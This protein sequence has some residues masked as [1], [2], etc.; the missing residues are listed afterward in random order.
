MT[1]LH[2]TAPRRLLGTLVALFGIGLGGCASTNVGN[3]WQCPLLQGSVCARVAEADPA[4]PQRVS[5]E[6]PATTGT[7]VE[8][9]T[10]RA[11]RYRNGTG[12]RVPV[13]GPASRSRASEP[14]CRGICRPQDRPGR[15]AGSTDDEPDGWRDT[16]AVT[17]SEGDEPQRAASWRDSAR[18]AEVLGRIWIAPYVDVM[19]VY[20]EASWVR[21]VIEPAGWRHAP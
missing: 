5:M 12:A 11:R 4:A 13:T 17:G 15:S 6:M 9:S 10:V 21:V 19:G 18:T 8:P 3:T 20:H 16:H 2:R 7:V 1:V 14:T